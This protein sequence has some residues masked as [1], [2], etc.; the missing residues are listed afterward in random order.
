M[1]GRGTHGGGGWN[2]HHDLQL[3][4]TNGLSCAIFAP[5][6]IYEHESDGKVTEEY[7][8]KEEAFW[9]NVIT[10]VADDGSMKLFVNPSC[11]AHYVGMVNEKW[12]KCVL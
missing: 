11:V 3:I 10:E 8:K 2:T 7:Q 1:W 9:C 6:W 4:R 5:G 12:V